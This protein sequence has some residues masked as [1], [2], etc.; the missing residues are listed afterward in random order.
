MGWLSNIFNKMNDNE[1]EFEC[2]ITINNELYEK[3]DANKM[4]KTLL[5]MNVTRGDFVRFEPFTEN[6]G[7][8]SDS[9]HF[10]EYEV[11]KVVKAVKKTWN[12]CF[13]S[14]IEIYLIGEK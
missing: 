10:K 13:L 1:V 5:L 9:M 6:K 12:G 11:S 2:K 14:A 4:A 7:G 3:K 8:Y